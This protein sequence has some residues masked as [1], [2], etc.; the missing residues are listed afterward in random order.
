[1]EK[2]LE[3]LKSL[4]RAVAGARDPQ[5]R[6]PGPRRLAIVESIDRLR[7]AGSNYRA[8][9]S[10]LG[11]PFQT[12]MSWRRLAKRRPSKGKLLRVRIK[13]EEAVPPSNELVVHGP[14]GLRIAGASV[15]EIASLFRAL[16]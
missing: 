13:S 16:S 2:Q 8:I 10:A 14:S 12:M 4:R 9:A 5:G 11:V 7:A 3:E 15:E 1:M 6:L